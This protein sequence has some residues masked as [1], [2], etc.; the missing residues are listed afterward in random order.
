M[1]TAT[2]ND[3]PTQSIACGLPCAGFAATALDHVNAAAIVVAS[4][5]TGWLGV[6]LL[7]TLMIEYR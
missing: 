5:C 4:T 6:P 1:S 2:Q 3:A 7:F